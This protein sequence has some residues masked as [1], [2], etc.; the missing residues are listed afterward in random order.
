ML[1]SIDSGEGNWLFR[2]SHYIK[3]LLLL[4]W[5]QKGPPCIKFFADSTLLY[6]SSKF[7]PNM[8]TVFVQNFVSGYIAM[9]YLRI[10]YVFILA[11]HLLYCSSLFLL[12]RNIKINPVPISSSWQCFSICYWNLNSIAAD[13]YA[14]LSL[15][16]A[17]NL[18]HSLDIIWR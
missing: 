7:L 5:F 15:Y 16:T 1:V 12:R 4:I 18:V 13:D 6:T 14:K 2:Q 11:Y 3:F 9:Q 17:Y 10:F 8:W